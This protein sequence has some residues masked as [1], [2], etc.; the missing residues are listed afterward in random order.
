M[1]VDLQALFDQAGRN[2]PAP[3]LDA[4]AVLR[5][6]RRS[7]RRRTTGLVAAAAA[8]TLALCVGAASQ[9]RR[10]AA[11]DPATPRPTAPATGSLGRLA[12]GL[13]GDI[14]LADGDGKH[15]VRI[16]DGTPDE[17]DDCGNLWA[18]G[19]VWSPDGRY[20]VYRGDE[21]GRD[22]TGT[23]CP[24]SANVHISDPSGGRIASFPSEGWR[25]AWSPDSTRV[26]T[27]VKFGSV[28]GVYGVDGVRQALLPVPVGGSLPGDFDPVWS[29]DGKSLVLPGGV[30]IPVDGSTPRQLSSD[31]PRSQWQFVY[32]PDG[33]HVA[34]VSDA[35]LVVAAADGSQARVLVPRRPDPPQGWW[36]GPAWSPTGDQIAFVSQK[37]GASADEGRVSELA[38]V[39]VTSGTVVPLADLGS[40]ASGGSMIEFSPEGD[41]VL[42]LRADAQHG[43]SLWSVRTDGSEPHELVAGADWGD[44]QLIPTR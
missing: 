23:D 39:D 38:L 29:P 4:D 17:V 22:I 25:V 24:S 41:Q 10:S 28:L 5:R 13:D 35:G 18:E 19:P 32:S 43:S 37:R 31:D 12:F 44:W 36:F 34:Y 1:S 15:R 21:N 27:W 11:P 7:R 20:F 9:W 16:A 30:E 3:A 26:A 33:A 14:Y 6:A 8:V 40:N 42:F 2:Q